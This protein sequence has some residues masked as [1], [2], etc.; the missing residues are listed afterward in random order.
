MSLRGSA[1]A[2]MAQ[3]PSARGLVVPQSPLMTPGQPS[4]RCLYYERG[5]GGST[6]IPIGGLSTASAAVPSAAL[7]Q[8]VLPGGVQ[9]PAVPQL[10]STGDKIPDPEEIKAQKEQYALDLEEQLR[11]GVELLGQTH[12]QQTEALHA[13][14]NQ[15]KHR[16]N[17]V[18]DQQVKQQELIL[19]QQYNEQLMKLQQ[20]AQAQR[21]GLEKQA[22]GLILEYQQRKVQEEF[23]AQ[24]SGIQKQHQEAQM[25]LAEEMQ[26]LSKERGTVVEASPSLS[27]GAA[28]VQLSSA[29]SMLPPAPAMYAVPNGSVVMPPAPQGTLRYV[30]PVGIPSLQVPRGAALSRGS[31]PTIGYRRG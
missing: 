31:T 7:P 5:C 14:A 8:P 17:L 2:S 19:S 29:P 25:R 23:M 1:T 11:K 26:K 10:A 30:P 9:F 20:A 18:L 13:S 28:S 27:I 15:E 12:K 16:Y 4:A 22:C 3:L 21:A 24:Q 6:N